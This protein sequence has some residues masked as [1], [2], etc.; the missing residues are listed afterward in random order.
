MSHKL[1]DN[2]VHTFDHLLSR[3]ASEIDSITNNSPP[4]GHSL[5]QTIRKLPRFS[6]TIEHKRETE[7]QIR[8][9]LENLIQIKSYKNGCPLGTK[10]SMMIIVGDE[11]N[12]LI[13][14]DKVNLDTFLHSGEI[15]KP[16][17][18]EINKNGLT[19]HASLILLEFIGMDI[20]KPFNCQNSNDLCKKEIGQRVFKFNNVVGENKENC[21]QSSKNV[22]IG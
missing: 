9:R 20:H 13:L 18:L 2:E 12:H 11:K 3:N 16:L 5:L 21:L 15:V 19:I 10:Q 17:N 4:F 22:I 7:F 14:F 8:F 6:I 1:V